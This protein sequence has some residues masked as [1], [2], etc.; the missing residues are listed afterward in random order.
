LDGLAV[1][2]FRSQL[3]ARLRALYPPHNGTTLFPM[4]RLLFVATLK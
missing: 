3:A 4:P 1:E 2:Q